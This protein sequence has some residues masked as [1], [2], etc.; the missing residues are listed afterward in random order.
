MEDAAECFGRKK[1]LGS[2]YFIWKVSAEV[3][4]LV[5]SLLSFSGEKGRWQLISKKKKQAKQSPTAIQDMNFEAHLISQVIKKHD[6]FINQEIM[7]SWRSRKRECHRMRTISVRLQSI[8]STGSKP[9]NS[10]RLWCACHNVPLAELCDDNSSLLYHHGQTTRPLWHRTHM[11]IMWR[12]DLTDQEYDHLKTIF[13]NDSKGK[14]IHPQSRGS[15]L[16]TEPPGFIIP[17][18]SS[19]LRHLS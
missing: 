14:V 5:G 16:P 19:F 3:P 11:E 8:Q 1:K 13:S 4:A 9:R 6:A 7:C 2:Q 12:K 18:I 15:L 10:L 17:T